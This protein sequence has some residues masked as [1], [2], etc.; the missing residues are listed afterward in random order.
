VQTGKT[1][2]RGG[3]NDAPNGPRT[4]VSAHLESEGQED[5]QRLRLLKQQSKAPRL[6]HMHPREGEQSRQQNDR[7][8]HSKSGDAK[9]YVILRSHLSSPSA[10]QSRKTRLLFSGRPGLAT[11]PL[12]YSQWP[13]GLCTE[14]R[15]VTVSV[16]SYTCLMEIEKLPKERL[17]ASR[18]A[19][20]MPKR[21]LGV[22]SRVTQRPLNKGTS[23]D[24]KS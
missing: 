2:P 9:L 23:L 5:P 24:V 18:Q 17:R 8:R 13:A 14:E 22:D 3:C 16:L 21:L 1:A 4:E 12:P 10:T 20:F 7:D 15:D 6:I 11:K 19:Y